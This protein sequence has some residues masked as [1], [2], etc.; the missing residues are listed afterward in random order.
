MI[1]VFQSIGVVDQRNHVQE[2]VSVVKYCGFLT[3]RGLWAKVMNQMTLKEF[4]EAVKAAVHARLLE[5]ASV[6]GVQGIQA[7]P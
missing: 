4:E 2:I 1:K 6:G 5:M 3:A 7:P